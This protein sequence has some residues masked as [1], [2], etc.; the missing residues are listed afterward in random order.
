MEKPLVTIICLCYNQSRFVVETLQ[1]VFEQTYQPIQLIVVD[2]CSTDH[3]AE[4]IETF[5]K[6]KSILFIKNKV[7][8]GSTKSFN[9]ALKQAKGDYVMDLAADDVMFPNCIEAL[10]DGFQQS[11]FEA[12]A[13]V[14]SNVIYIDEKSNFLS[15]HFPVNNQNKVLQ[16]RPI[17]QIY[18][19]ILR[20]GDGF[21]SASTLFR[22]C[23]FEK[24]GG[25]DENLFFEDFD[26][27]VRAS[28]NFH[29]DF[30]DQPLFQKRVVE[31][32]MGTLFHDKKNP[33]NKIINRS[34]FAV[35][36]KAY[37]LNE[38]KQEFKALMKRVNYALGLS[39][40]NHDFGLFLKLLLFKTKVFLKT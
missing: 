7:N 4:T 25:Y 9:L 27:W 24:L 10:V 33:K 11:E 22:T 18:I 26:F 1:S 36:K 19:E 30:V 17:G 14:S 38:S 28:R 23:I 3:S 40:K 5:L 21:F 32:S 6:N 31:N 15:Y 13:A 2:D 35:L 20:G 39:L 16:K 8:L 29:F 12:V 34:Y 37:L